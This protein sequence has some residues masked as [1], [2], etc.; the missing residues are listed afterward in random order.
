MKKLREQTGLTQTDIAKLIGTSKT[1]SSLYEKGLRDLS[2]KALNMLSTIEIFLENS[3]EIHAT[4]KISL[5]DQ[6]ALV[7][8]LKKLDYDQKRAGQQYEMIQEKLLRMEEAYTSNRKLLPLL[9]KLKTKLKGAMA[10]PYVDV[11]EIRC[12]EKLKSCGLHQQIL[13]R[14]QLALL[15]TEV[16]SA[17]QLIEAYQDFGVP[18]ER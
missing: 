7:A 2:P 13:L 12:L 15:E 5:K 1:S 3:D 8:M 4:E 6:K 14:H 9:N 16:A 17:Q 10:N 18:V 11:L